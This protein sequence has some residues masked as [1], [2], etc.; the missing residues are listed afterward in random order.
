LREVAAGEEIRGRDQWRQYWQRY[1][2]AFPD[3]RLDQT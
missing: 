2:K 3:L 1:L